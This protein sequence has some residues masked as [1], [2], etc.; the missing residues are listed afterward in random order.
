MQQKFTLTEIELLLSLELGKKMQLV[1]PK[2][3]TLNFIKQFACT[4][5]AEKKLPLP[6]AG[7]MLN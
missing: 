4:Y 7:M 2:A 3:Q 6:L 5:H 1:S